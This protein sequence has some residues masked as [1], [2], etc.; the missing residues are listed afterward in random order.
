MTWIQTSPGL[1]TRRLGAIE[2]SQV[3]YI[4]A[5]SP[6]Q[7]E[8]IKIHCIADFTSPHSQSEVESA[9]KEAWK[10]LRL[11]KSPDIATEFRDGQTTYQVPS[12]QEV[13][14]WVEDTFMLSPLE[15]RVHKTVSDTYGRA[16]WLPTCHLVPKSPQSSAFRGTIVLLI[17]HW[18]TEAGGAF[19]IVQRLFQFAGELLVGDQ[20]RSAL[21][22]HKSG[23]ETTLLTPAIEDVLMPGKSSSPESKARINAHMNNYTSHLPTIDFPVTHSITA[24][25]SSMK[26]HQRIYTTDSTSA[27]VKACKSNDISVTAAVHAAYLGAVWRLAPAEKAN[28]SYACMMPAQTRDRLPKQSPYRDQGCWSSA[29]MMWLTSAPNQDFLTRARGLRDQ[30]KLADSPV[31][32]FEDAREVINR[33]LHPSGETPDGPIAVPWFTSIGL[34]DNKAGGAPTIVS[35]HGALKIDA[36]TVWAD[37][38]GPGIVLGQWS[39]RGRLNIQIHWNVAQQDDELISK[40]LDLLEDALKTGLGVQVAL[41]DTRGLDEIY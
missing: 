22:M 12:P 34:L 1:F 29:N 19:K 39:F 41:E 31:W 27:L 26:R 36:V 38:P 13:E 3:S 6:N 37:N 5:S 20:T 2:Q 35:D 32:L 16:Q 11:L 24:P 23:E 25:S 15:A 14:S 21:R 40:A 7:R 8:P 10:A 4:T 18:R 28:R 33:T 17:S 9:F 30:Y